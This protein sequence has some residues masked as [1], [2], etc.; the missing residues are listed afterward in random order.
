MKKALFYSLLA[1]GLFSFQDLKAQENNV[2]ST[3]NDGEIISS[4]LA[5]YGNY[6]WK[7]SNGPYDAMIIGVYETPQYKSV[8]ERQAIAKNPIKSSGIVMVKVNSENGQ[9]KKGDAITTSSE[10][11]V[12]MKATGPGMIVGVALEDATGSS[13]LVKIRVLIQYVR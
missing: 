12:G 10:A 13:G 9:I 1:V 3:F 7:T 8:Q 6:D 2:S 5:Q 11:G 4:Q